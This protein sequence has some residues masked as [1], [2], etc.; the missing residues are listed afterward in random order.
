MM[1]SV[2][3]GSMAVFLL[4]VSEVGIASDEK[5]MAAERAAMEW[6]DL[7]DSGQYEASWEEAAS[8]FQSQVS[9][10]DWVKAV[11]AAREPFGSLVNRELVSATHTTSLP[12]APD[13]DY[14][15]LRFQTEFES[16]SQAVETVTPKLE[17]GHWKVSGYYVK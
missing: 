13:G 4:V 6:L 10:P 8:R 9:K 2:Y 5:T 16:K 14:V 17:E 3:V 7:V 12:G 1:K 11:S 15:V